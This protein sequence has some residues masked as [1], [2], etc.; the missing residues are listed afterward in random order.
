MEK[1]RQSK[2]GEGISNIFTLYKIVVCEREIEARYNAKVFFEH[3]NQCIVGI[4][5]EDVE[6][7]LGFGM[8]MI[9]KAIMKRM[10]RSDV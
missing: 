8:L 2:K 4:L 10:S 3:W 1:K 9:D 6:C 5:F 7:A